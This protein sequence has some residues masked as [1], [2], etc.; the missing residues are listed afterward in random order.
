MTRLHEDLLREFQDFAQTAP[1]AKC[2]M[3]RISQRL[4]EKDGAVQLGRLLSR[5]S[6][7]PAS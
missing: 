4:H 6:W 2:L 1:A 7:T 5:R 3:E